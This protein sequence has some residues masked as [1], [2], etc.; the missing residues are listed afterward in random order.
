V[1]GTRANLPRPV[2]MIIVYGLFLVIVGVTATAQTML[3][4]LHFSTASLEATVGSDAA[5]IRT[6]ANGFLQQSDLTGATPARV[7]ELETALDALLHRGEL[8][9]VDLRST[10]GT[11]LFTTEPTA[12]GQVEARSAGFDKAVGASGEPAVDAAL[13]DGSQPTEAPGAPLGASQVL[14]AYFP[15]VGQDGKAQAVIAIYRDAAPLFAKLAAIRLQVV[16]VTLSAAAI[17]AVLLFFIFRAA[18]RRITVQTAQLVESTRR[19]PLTG[20]LNHGALVGELAV[21]I[22]EARRDGTS[23]GVALVDI[24]GFRLMNETYGHEAGDGALNQVAERLRRAM[25]ATGTIG[26]SGPDEFLIFVP[27]RQVVALEPLL[28]AVRTE[29]ADESLQ[30][31][32]TERLPI[33]VSAGIA[34]FPEHAGSVTELLSL[35]AVVLSEAKASGGDAI[36]VAGARAAQSDQARSFDVLQGLIIA[37]D[38]KDRYTKRH[39]EDVA[40]YAV[41]LAGELGLD[42]SFVA[43]LRTAG[44]LHDVGK[45]GIPDGVLRK[46][47][48]LTAGEYDI[49]KQH[50]A[51]GDSIVRNVDNVDLVRAGIRHHHERWDGHGYLHALAG[52]DIPLIA[53]ILAVGDA[54]SAM[55]TTRP[56]RKAL[57]VEEAIRRLGDAAGS[58]LDETLVAAF[59]RGLETVADAPLPGQPSTSQLWVPRAEVA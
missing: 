23:I 49:V 13:L 56:Y 31:E 45:I 44:L 29:L 14:R 15:L 18:Q 33:T 2:L 27:A 54:F 37:V 1:F 40:R 26:R 28:E 53:R 12:R 35:V 50:V 21:A 43:T 38:T 4:S 47:G 52:E 10:T 16:L 51:L 48:Q 36:R 41:F 30:I 32:A 39:S 46:P 20:L 59:I 58:Q 3:V 19:D 57:T 7:A 42:P 11:V 22:E 24:D 5:T 9:R 34:V 6:F 25:P 17:V 8:L 55:T